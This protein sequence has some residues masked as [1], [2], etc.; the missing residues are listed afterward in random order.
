MKGSSGSL[1][2]SV[3]LYE[4]VFGF[5]TNI[6]FQLVFFF[7]SGPVIHLLHIRG[8]FFST[9]T[10]FLPCYLIVQISSVYKS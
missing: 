3:T 10:I 1:N 2:N 9:T 5:I 6:L 4:E 7:I 8:M